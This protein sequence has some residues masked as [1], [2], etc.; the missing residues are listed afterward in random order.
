MLDDRAKGEN[1]PL[2]KAPPGE[3]MTVIRVAADVK[4]RRHLENL[5]IMSGAELTPLSYSDGNMIV[6]VHD[7]R[8]ALDRDIAQ[9]IIVRKSPMFA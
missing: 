7:S 9:N 3:S 4:T 6:R 1:M 5:G 2:V 8:I